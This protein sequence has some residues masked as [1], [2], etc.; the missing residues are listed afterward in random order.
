MRRCRSAG[1]VAKYFL[2]QLG[3]GG[4]AQTTTGEQS[5]VGR[6]R[7]I[8]AFDHLG[9]RA[10]FAYACARGER[11]SVG[12]KEEALRALAPF[13]NS[14]NEADWQIDRSARLSLE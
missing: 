1:L 10:L 11:S 12:R 5:L 7:A 6:T 4:I 14:F 3:P 8:V 9:P 2:L 13:G